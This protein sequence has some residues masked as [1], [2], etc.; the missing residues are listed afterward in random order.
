MQNLLEAPAELPIYYVFI[1]TSVGYLWS[2]AKLSK[3]F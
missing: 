3:F 2:C 1:T